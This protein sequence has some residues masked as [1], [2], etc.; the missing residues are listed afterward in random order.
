[1]NTSAKNRSGSEPRD[2]ENDAG[3]ELQDLT[4][5]FTY[6]P[7]K[8]AERT[9]NTLRAMS[10]ED[11][12]HMVEALNT[13]DP[14]AFFEWMSSQPG[15]QAL[16]GMML[17]SGRT[18]LIAR[19]GDRFEDMPDLEDEDVSDAQQELRDYE[20]GEPGEAHAQLDIIEREVTSA[21]RLDE[22]T[23]GFNDKTIVIAS[24]KPRTG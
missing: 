17:Q 15:E 13:A 11:I 10:H 7:P 6:M 5:I 9:R 16:A 21:E 18:I 12:N 8:L 4:E 22:D 20:N 23:I 1:M 14:N 19:D 24:R 2:D 3:M